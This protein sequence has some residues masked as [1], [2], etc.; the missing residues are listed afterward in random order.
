MKI[1]K[2]P[3]LRVYWW[4]PIDSELRSK[5]SAKHCSWQN[6]QF[7]GKNP[8][9]PIP[10]S[11]TFI[12]RPPPTAPPIIPA[13]ASSTSGGCSNQR[14]TGGWSGWRWLRGSPV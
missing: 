10:S 5:I 14:Q 13:Q 3:K 7:S 11:L 8:Q 6:P 4:V 2:F 12:R 9:C 1:W